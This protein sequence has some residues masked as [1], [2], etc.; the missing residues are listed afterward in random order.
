MSEWPDCGERRKMNQEDHDLLLN[1]ANDT[2][3]MREWTKT[4]ESHDDERFK[5]QGEKIDFLTKS[6]YL[7]IGGL[8]VAEFVLKAVLK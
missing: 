6:I 3:H 5:R 1:I 2:R 7:G 8:I 4:H